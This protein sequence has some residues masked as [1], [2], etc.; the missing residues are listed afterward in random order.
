VIDGDLDRASSRRVPHEVRLRYLLFG[1]SM[2]AYMP[3]ELT[4]LSEVSRSEIRDGVEMGGGGEDGG[5]L[6]GEER[7]D[8]NDE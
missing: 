3:A 5:E 8:D 1:P 2:P 4:T 6:G 7:G